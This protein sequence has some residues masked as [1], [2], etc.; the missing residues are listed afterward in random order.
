MTLDDLVHEVYVGLSANRVR[1]GLTILGIVIGISSVIAM[2][3]IGQGASQSISSSIESLGSN[4]LQVVPGQL[5]GGP[6]GFGVSQ[7]RGSAQTLTLEDAEAIEER[8]T[9]IAAI[10][11]AVSGRY[12]VTARGTNTNTTINGVSASYD[13]IR[14][15]EIAEGT[16]LTDSHVSSGSRVAVIGPTVREDLFADS[17]GVLGGTIRINGA[18][19]IVVGVTESKGGGGFQNQDDI[20]FIPLST[21]QR[22]LTGN[23]FVSTINVQAS[24]AESMQ[25][26]QADITELLMTRHRI[27]TPEEADF[28]VLNQNDLL[29]T[30]GDVTA[31]LTYLLGA[32]GSISLLVGGIGIMN[33]MLTSVTERTKEIGL[34]KAIGAKRRDISLQFLGEA[35][36]LTLIG[37]AIGILLGWGISA[38]VNATGLV[39]TSVTAGSVLLAF[40]VSAAT[41][42]IFGWYPAR[43]A[44]DLS[45]ID[46][47]RYE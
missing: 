40:G 16:F 8:V 36:M 38:A 4:L 20:I 26:V 42:V 10:A 2:I 22:L 3:S 6:G 24:D 34:R 45:P 1:S 7:G 30:A 15:I 31:T 35:V 27:D 29:S 28:S 18:N 37:G 44:A 43:R 47:L 33:M 11:S 12:Q 41:G 14:N 13:T 19:Y 23:Q 32:I 17:P 9:G 21:A 25:Q 39:T 46:A 5:R